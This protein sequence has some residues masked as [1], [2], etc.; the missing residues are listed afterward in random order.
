MPEIALFSGVLS[1]FLPENS[2]FEPKI[3]KKPFFLIPDKHQT[4]CL[5]STDAH[6]QGFSGFGGNQ[7]K[8]YI[9]SIEINKKLRVMTIQEFRCHHRQSEVNRV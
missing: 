8:P 4:R 1:D 2:I 7:E 6:F 3:D 9:C 5:L